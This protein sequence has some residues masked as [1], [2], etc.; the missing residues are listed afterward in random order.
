[1]GA[2][3]REIQLRHAKA[4]LS[5]VVDDAARGEPSIITRHGRPQAVVLSRQHM[6]WIRVRCTPYGRVLLLHVL[7]N[8]TY[9]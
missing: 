8:A 2:A 7:I 5:A 1:M 9:P 4:P 3:V 6:A